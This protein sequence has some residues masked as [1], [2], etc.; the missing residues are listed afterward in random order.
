MTLEQ[1]RARLAAIEAERRAIHEATGEGEMTPEQVARWEVLDTEEPTVRAQI[2]TE[3]RAERVRES[4]ARWGSVQVRTTG[5]ISYEMRMDTRGNERAGMILRAME[6]LISDGANQRHFEGLVRRHAVRDVMWARNILARSNPVYDQAWRMVMSGN[7]ILLNEEQRAAIAVGTGTQGGFLV[8]T[9]LDPTLIITNS[10]SSNIVRSISRVV[11]LTQE[12]VWHGVSTAGVTASWDAELAEVSDDSPTF[13]A[14]N[15]PV[16][17]AQV[18]VQAT[19]DA[20]AD[21][22]IADEVL[23]LFAD[24]RDRLEG[25]AHAVGSGVGQPT[26][27][28]TA[29]DANTNV[30]ITSTT[31]A[32]I[33]L[34]DIHGVYRQ[35]PVRWRGKGTWLMNPLYSLAIKALGT[36][37]SAS[38]STDITQPVADRLIGRPLVESDDAPTTQT[39]TAVDN[40]L[41]FGDFSNM[42][43]VDKP[44]ST[45]TQ[46]IPTLFNTANNLPDGRVGWYM[47]W[48]NGSDS[49]NDLAFRLLQD[50]T[51]A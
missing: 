38:Y 51:S 40:E 28:F 10:G 44:G 21:T 39:T 33:G 34:V 22:G 24:A 23:G 46:Y 31:A 5:D 35:V 11:T 15:V 16:Y 1:L 30:E 43:I 4:R 3:E 49:V 36:A 18:F 6:G 2:E 32:T 19:L 42:V 25:A 9:H 47:R 41:V 7:G 50:K 37:L 29:L 14:P 8:P 20:L 17:G 26:G 13:L 27:I 12:N 48:R 45:T